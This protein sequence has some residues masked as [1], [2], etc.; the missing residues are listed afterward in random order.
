M[1]AGEFG[2][3]I[4][5]YS[6]R[7]ELQAEQQGTSFR[8]LILQPFGSNVGIG[9]TIPSSTLDVRSST[10]T[11]RA[12]NYTSSLSVLVDANINGP[13]IS[14]GAGGDNSFMEFGSYANLNNLDT[15]SRDLKIFSTS[16]PDAFILRSAT[17][18]IGIG[19]TNPGVAANRLSVANPTGGTMVSLN[20]GG[21]TN[22]K[23]LIFTLDTTNNTASIDSV[24]QG[25]AYR[26]LLLNTGGGNVGV[27]TTNPTYKLHVIGSFAATTKS[28][29]IDHPTK[30]GMKLR[31][32]SLEGPENGVYVRGRSQNDV[33]NL[34]DYWTGLVDETSITVNL[35]PIGESA[36]PRVKE[37]M[38]NQVMV[39]SK[40]EGE[41]D[42]FYTV[43]AER[44]DV[45]KLEVEI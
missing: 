45:E 43:Y 40:E 44:V 13:R 33:I 21:T 23:E 14:F 1:A 22:R 12:Q 30:E 38:N 25:I 16:V 18:N 19:T 26:P 8:P 32:G 36:T 20:D 35:T 3:Q 9:T 11:I 31:H 27:G 6:D 24:Q 37:I 4:L 7:T 42:Y 5:P 34:P 17:G 10:G 28:F 15:K 41:L 2:L 39:F 29:V